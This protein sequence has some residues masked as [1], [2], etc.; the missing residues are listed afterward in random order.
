V[1]SLFVQRPQAE[2]V[3]FGLAVVVPIV[4][5]IKLRAEN[6]DKPLGTSLVVHFDMTRDVAVLAL[7]NIAHP[8]FL[9]PLYHRCG[10]ARPVEERVARMLVEVGELVLSACHRIPLPSYAYCWI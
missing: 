2:V 6:G 1:Q 5:L 10:R 7:A 3:S 8:E 9:A 4:L